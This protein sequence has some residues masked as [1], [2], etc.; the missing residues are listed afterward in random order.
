MPATTQRDFY[1]VLGVS[2]DADEKQIKD[3]FRQL[4]VKV[5]PGTQPDSGLRLAGKGLPNFR[6]RGRGNLFVRISVRVPEQLSAE[7]RKL[8]ERLR[9][10]RTRDG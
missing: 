9:E 3:A 6:G 8:F 4:A 10:I 5:P 7:E 2:R 1:E